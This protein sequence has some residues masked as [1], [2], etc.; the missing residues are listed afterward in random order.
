MYWAPCYLYL[1]FLSGSTLCLDL[2]SPGTHCHLTSPQ[3][4]PPSSSAWIPHLQVWAIVFIHL[5][6]PNPKGT[7]FSRQPQI[8]AWCVWSTIS[9]QVVAPAQPVSEP[10]SRTPTVKSP[11]LALH[12]APLGW[13]RVRV[14]FRE[15]WP[16]GRRGRRPGMLSS[17]TRKWTRGQ[18]GSLC[19][20]QSH[21]SHSTEQLL[22]FLS[23][24]SFSPCPPHSPLPSFYFLCL[25]PQLQPQAWLV[26]VKGMSSL[27][28]PLSSGD[29]K[30]LR[31]CCFSGSFFCC[32]KKATK[33]YVSPL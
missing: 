18:P 30:Q 1:C 28:P 21:T 19:P 31:M 29:Q 4:L 2:T 24:L 13:E 5:L 23:S 25:S 8:W 20:S 27:A 3:P 9:S 33:F 6:P 11:G 17:Y 32:I 15:S 16:G 26:L 7:T 14:A 12:C 10:I 22:S